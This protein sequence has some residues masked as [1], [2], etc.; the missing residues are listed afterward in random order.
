MSPCL[1]DRAPASGHH[2]DWFENKKE[3]FLESSHTL[4]EG[5]RLMGLE[6]ENTVL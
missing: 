3:A 5:L 2:E 1:W 6:L 4:W